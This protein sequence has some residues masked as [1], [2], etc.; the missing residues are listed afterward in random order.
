MRPV[1]AIKVMPKEIAS[2][3]NLMEEDITVPLYGEEDLPKIPMGDM[4]D[5]GIS[6]RVIGCGKYGN[7]VEGEAKGVKL[8]L[9][10]FDLRFEQAAIALVIEQT[11]YKRLLAL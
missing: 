3:R 2:R 1:K 10:L 8:A 5:L 11:A 7:V 6:G 4:E 9:K